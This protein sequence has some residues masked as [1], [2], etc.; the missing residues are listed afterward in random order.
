MNEIEKDYFLHFLDRELLETQ[1]IYNKLLEQAIIRDVRFILFHSIGDLILS[2]SFLFESKYAYAIFNEFYPLFLSGKFIIAI[3]YDSLKKM[4]STKQDQY[5][6]N[7]KIFPNYFNDLWHVIE[8]CGIILIPKREDTTLYIADRMLNEENYGTKIEDRQCVPYIMEAVEYRGKRAITHHLFES[9]YIKR[10]VSANDQ[11]TINSLITE[12]YIRSYLE[13]FDATI[14]TGLSCGIFKYDYLSTNFPLSD[15]AFWIKLYKRIGI[16]QFVCTCKVSTIIAVLSSNIQ[17][18]FIQ[19]V[20][21]W[22]SYFENKKIG[23]KIIGKKFYRLINSIPQ[24]AELQTEDINMYFNRIRQVEDILSNQ[25]FIE[26]GSS[27]M[28]SNDKE[29]TVFVVHG[30]NVQIKKSIFTFLRS[31]NLYP[32]EW[33]TAV[34]MTSKGAPTTLEVI[35]TGMR[36]AGGTI[37][38]FT[39]DDLAKLKEEL[40][41]ADEHYDFELQPRQNV[42]FEAGMAI[43]LRPQSTV[44]VRVGKL[45]EISDLTGIN[46]INLSDSPEHRNALVTRLKTIGLIVDTTGSDWLTAGNFSI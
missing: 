24:F 16:Y 44:I 43:A 20:F 7:E 28:L 8:E 5:K 25:H 26:R 38:L 13:Y 4:I 29:K 3:T 34:A 46:Y 22:L 11:E 42:L 31:L 30:R 21:R 41:N 33:E 39:G 45:R 35:E 19:T 10:D 9:V 23:V 27:C 32:L 40:W 18:N 1:G 6:G 14:A 17:Y 37:I 2:A 36:N 15:V 12:L